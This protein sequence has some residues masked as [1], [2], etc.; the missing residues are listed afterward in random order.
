MLWQLTVMTFVMSLAKCWAQ[1]K[2]SVM[3]AMYTE[4]HLEPLCHRDATSCAGTVKVE[5]EV[6]TFTRVGNPFT[7]SKRSFMAEVF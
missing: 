6:P 4:M 1:H 5:S 7:Y 3:A 2:P